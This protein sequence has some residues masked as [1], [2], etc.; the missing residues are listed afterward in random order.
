VTTILD[1]HP[2][3]IDAS[4]ECWEWTA[5]Q[6]ALGYGR[7]RH[8]GRTAFASRVSLSLSLGREI[9]DGLLALHSCDNPPCVNPDHL[10]EGTH[11]DNQRDAVGHAMLREARDSNRRLSLALRP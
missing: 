2:E 10:R 4:G 6:N 8:D 3:K 9:G 11:S 7:V 5:C 1:L